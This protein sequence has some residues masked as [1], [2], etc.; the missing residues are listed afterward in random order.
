MVHFFNFNSI[1]F[2]T[3]N[4]IRL[5]LPYIIGGYIRIY[6]LHPKILWT[7][8]GLIYFPLTIISEIIFDIL[9]FKSNTCIFIK[10]HLNLS[11]YMN[12]I[13]SITGSMGL[14]YFFKSIKFY[15]KTINYISASVLGIYLIHGNSNIL[16]YIY[17]K[18]FE[19]NN[20]NDNFFFFKYIIKTILII[21]F[22]L[23]I[24]IIRR[25]TIGLLFDKLIKN[26]IFILQNY[27]NL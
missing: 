8:M 10:F 13:L 26:I 5:L 20:L 15:S 12:S 16:P 7:F 24:D 11:Y 2:E 4:L 14:L 1:I 27:F 22:S 23:L 6:D 3:T 21:G 9:T 18:W 17:N 25:K 19:I